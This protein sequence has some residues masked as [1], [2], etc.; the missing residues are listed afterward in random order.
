MP[1]FPAEPYASRNPPPTA[2]HSTKSLHVKAM[3]SETRIIN[4]AA[5]SASVLKLKIVSPPAQSAARAT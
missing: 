5:E 1:P 3:R 2:D 4:L